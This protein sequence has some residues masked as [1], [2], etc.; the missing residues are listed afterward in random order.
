[1]QKNII[2]IQKN[3][4]EMLSVIEEKFGE[5]YT[6]NFEDLTIELKNLILEFIKGDRQISE[7]Y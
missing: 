1:M 5:E 7:K 3:A 6:E 2:Q 4:K